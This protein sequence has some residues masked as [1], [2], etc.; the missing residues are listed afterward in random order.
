[1]FMAINQT[2][3][4]L[5]LGGEGFGVMVV[6][7]VIRKYLE[8]MRTWW[9]NFECLKQMTKIALHFKLCKCMVS[10]S[11]KGVVAKLVKW[12]LHV[13]LIIRVLKC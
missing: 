3:T 7:R 2:K 1:M 5:N 6:W 13:P 10:H 4:V 11:G 12:V 8:I 9:K